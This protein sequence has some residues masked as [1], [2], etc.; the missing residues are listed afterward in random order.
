MK[1]HHIAGHELDDDLTR[2]WA[3]LQRAEPVFESAFFHPE[4]TRAVAATKSNVELGIVEDGGRALAFFPFERVSR[5]LGAPVGGLLSDY[6]GIVFDKA[7]DPAFNP[8]TLLRACGLECWDFD[9]LP[10]AQALIPHDPRR[11]FESPQID[12][13][14][15]YEAYARR[16]RAAGSHMIDRIEYLERRLVREAGPV[17]FAA[18]E[19]DEEAFERVLQWKSAQFARTQKFDIFSAGAA[20]DVLRALRRIETPE[21]AG[22]LSTLRAG[23]R[24][25]AA[26]FGL[27]SGGAF[28]YWFPAY[29]V[30]FARYSPGHILVLKLAAGC[31]ALGI[32]SIDLGAGAQPYK[33][34]L[35]TG[36]NLLSAGSFHLSN[37]FSLTRNVRRNLI[38]YARKTPFA[39]SGRS[40]LRAVR[41][42]RG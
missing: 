5:R 29:D 4:F 33:L 36:A 18:Q 25:I 8:L 34:R 22:T 38:D 32:R 21:F 14:H 31:E 11:Q 6:H 39:D 20:R 23:D 2:Q 24:L 12:L 17:R 19:S 41:A 10:A 30:D 28:H 9:H 35:A 40:L 13:S 16:K 7:L 26:H 27:R 15:G 3:A 37:W 1:I 42:L